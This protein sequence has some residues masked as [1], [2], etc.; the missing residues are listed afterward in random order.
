MKI[1]FTNV[2]FLRRRLLE[3]VCETA[4]EH[5]GQPTELLEMS[6]SVVSPEEI[7]ALNRDYR[8]VD[9]VTDVLSF[10]AVEAGRKV[11]D[12]SAF[13]ADVDPETGRLNIGDIVI[14]QKRAVR[15]AKEYGHSLRR[16]MCFLTTHGLLHL[17]GYDHMNE[18]DEKQM[19]SLQDEILGKAKITR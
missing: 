18:S 15:Q 13:S 3:R 1:L 17:L 11:V 14:C 6:L 9:A 8:N 5:L 4:L 16:E 19:F 12:L 7:R 10:P 2:C